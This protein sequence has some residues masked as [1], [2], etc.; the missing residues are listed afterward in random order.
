MAAGIEFVEGIVL[1]VEVHAA[2]C[3]F[4]GAGFSAATRFEVP[5]SRG[6]LREEWEFHEPDGG[7]GSTLVR[8]RYD[9]GRPDLTNLLARVSQQYGPLKN[10][11]LEAVFSDLYVRAFGLGRA[12]ETSQC[13]GAEGDFTIRALKRDYAAL[14]AYIVAYLRS[15][16]EEPEACPLVTRFVERFKH[17]DCILTLNYDTILERH[18]TSAQPSHRVMLM[19]YRIGPAGS[20]NGGVAP[21]MFRNLRHD[22]RGIFAKL[23]GAIDWSTC[24]NRACPNHRYIQSD[25][26]WYGPR[27]ERTGPHPRCVDCGRSVEPVIVP[28]IGTK[29]FA[30]FPKL[31]VM[32]SHAYEA[33]RRS[34]RWVFMGVSLATTDVHLQALVR[35]ASRDAP[36]FGQGAASPGRVCVVSKTYDDARAVAQRLVAAL[37]PN[38]LEVLRDHRDGIALFQ[39][40]E[41][42]LAASAETDR[43]REDRPD[44]L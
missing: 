25:S 18:C 2:V 3:H 15:K 44:S 33:L 23:H 30:R 11:D 16:S 17:Q 9:Q 31:S 43:D 22:Q 24:P 1:P 34:Q 41:E 14:V 26:P 10:L 4:L 39:S 36:Y 21:P 42:Y 27:F 32:W 5:V 29:P 12:W 37:S 28:P 40:V 13:V 38:A 35:S 6:F 20:T 8:A 19:G 7:G